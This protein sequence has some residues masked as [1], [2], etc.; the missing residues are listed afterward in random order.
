MNR[1]DY[2]HA[3]LLGAVMGIGFLSLFYV[4]FGAD[5]TTKPQYRPTSNFEVIDS[6]KGCDVVRY[7][8]NKM[9]TYKYFIHCNDTNS[10]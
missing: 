3:M 6:Y 1:P 4:F 10:N 7:D 8:D 2:Y 9:A 5:A